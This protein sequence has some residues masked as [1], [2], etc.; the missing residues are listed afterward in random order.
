[1]PAENASSCVF[2]SCGNKRQIGEDCDDGN[3]NNGDGCSSSCTIESGFSCIA[4]FGS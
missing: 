4:D 2:P 3:L 1:M